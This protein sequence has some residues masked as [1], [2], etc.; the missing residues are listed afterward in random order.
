VRDLFVRTIG[1]LS[2]LTGKACGPFY[3]TAIVISLYEVFTRYALNAPTVWTT[4]A[5]MCAIGAAWMLSVGAV[6]QQNRH[7]TVTVLELLLGR[8]V[9]Q[10]LS[11][12]SLGLSMLAVSGLLWASFMPAVHAVQRMERSGSAFN[13]PV[14]TFLKVLLVAALTMYLL[15]L[16]AR[17]IEKRTSET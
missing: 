6:T 16:L 4:E 12:V 3:V 10:V 8:K 11:K 7:I 14:P 15:Q 17:L 9:W 13:P 5:I 2:V 1:K